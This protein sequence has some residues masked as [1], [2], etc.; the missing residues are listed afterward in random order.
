MIQGPN[1][2]ATANSQPLPV[3]THLQEAPASGGWIWSLFTL[4]LL[5][6]GAIAWWQF[7]RSRPAPPPMAFGPALV[8][9]MQLESSTIEERSSF[10]GVLEAQQGVMLKPEV[11]GQV[12]QIFVSSGDRVATGDAIVR[13]SQERNQAE[14]S[15]AEANKEVRAAALA[16]AESQVLAA[17]ANQTRAE[18]EVALQDQE[19]ER[20]QG[21]VDAGAVARQQLEIA[22]RTQE[23]AMASLRATEEQV[24]A[25]QAAV[26]QAEAALQ[27]SQA[28]VTVV[29]SDLADTLITAPITGTIGDIPIKLG[30]FVEVG[31]DLTTVVQNR[32]LDLSLSVP[33]EYRSQLNLGL[34]VE[35]TPFVGE[36]AIAG[37]I[38]FIS[39]QVNATTQT[40]TVEAVF[41]N[42]QGWLNDD[43]RVEAS[44]IW[45][46]HSG[47]LV[48]ATAI[49]RLAGQTFVFVATPSSTDEATG[50]SQLIARQR[51]V[52][53]GSIQGNDYQVL[54]GVEPGDSIVVS[55]ILNLSNGMAIVPK[56]ETQSEETQS[57]EIQSE[58][59]QL[60]TEQ[61]E[62]GAER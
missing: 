2:P 28:Q 54:E 49:S 15:T 52:T 41:N 12:V 17:K 37:R 3:S 4:L 42:A 10:V 9:L 53:L 39:P 51:L 56:E 30:D 47:V 48:P 31:A 55:G 20:L 61:L 50:E 33:L 32:T 14:V 6:G 34:P 35:I 62:T 1:T 25:A 43:Q 27:Q 21:L 16:N 60:E 44:I 23:M 5:A 29:Q 18:A 57:E 8:E 13:L 36:E 46:E 45:Q 19:V 7:G 58:A 38:N 11:E 22:M 24:Q 59:E 26:A 40:V